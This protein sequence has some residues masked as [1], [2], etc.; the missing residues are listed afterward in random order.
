MLYSTLEQK[1]ES[2]ANIDNLQGAKQ[3]AG[4]NFKYVMLHKGRLCGC[5]LTK[6]TLANYIGNAANFEI[7]TIKQFIRLK[8][9]NS[10]LQTQN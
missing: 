4:Q 2:F 10:K 5:G 6:S 3:L 8:T 9:E 1:L 7:L